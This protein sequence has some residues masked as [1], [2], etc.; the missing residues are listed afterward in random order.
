MPIVFTP[1][2]ES[3]KYQ[4]PSPEDSAMNQ[5]YASI[6]LSETQEMVNRLN[7]N[8]SEMMSERFSICI[9]WRRVKICLTVE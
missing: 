7:G 2:E 1:L 9:G 6:L 3:M 4:E 5:K 8:N